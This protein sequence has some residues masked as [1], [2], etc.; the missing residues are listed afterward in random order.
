MSQSKHL[1]DVLRDLLGLEPSND[2][3][4]RDSVKADDGP[5]AKLTACNEELVEA[6]GQLHALHAQ[7][8]ALEREMTAALASAL[9]D[10]QAGKLADAS[11]SRGLT[12]A[13]QSTLDT[14]RASLQLA[15]TRH[16]A[17]VLERN[18][19]L[20]ALRRQRADA[21]R[22]SDDAAPSLAVDDTAANASIDASAHDG[23]RTTLSKLSANAHLASYV[24]RG[25]L[26]LDSLHSARRSFRAVLARKLHPDELTH[27]RYERAA[28]QVADTVRANLTDSVD[29]LGVLVELDPAA[30][31]MQLQRADGEAQSGVQAL[32]DRLALHGAQA[33]RLESLLAR[34]DEALTALLSTAAAV[35]EM[36][37]LNDGERGDFNTLIADLETLTQRAQLYR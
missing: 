16:E 25:L 27:Q 20:T 14:V 31:E 19:L 37:A 35:A 36:P 9:A 29:V 24:Q 26:Q 30:I 4:P 12:T 28:Q 10:E 2:A 32:R 15:Q 33:A 13:L 17:L 7:G 23:L 6:A 5:R 22:D 3:G 18:A 8:D 21:C 11:R 34:N 1:W